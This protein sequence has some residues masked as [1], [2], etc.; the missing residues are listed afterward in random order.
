MARRLAAEIRNH[1]VGMTVGY[2]SFA[3]LAISAVR[4]GGRTP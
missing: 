2:E 1:H 3:P 4:P